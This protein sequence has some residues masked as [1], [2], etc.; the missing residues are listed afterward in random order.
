MENDS[1]TTVSKP[2]E[3]SPVNNVLRLFGP[4]VLAIV[5]AAITTSILSWLVPNWLIAF[6]QS[7]HG[8]GLDFFW[9]NMTEDLEHA[10]SIGP[11]AVERYHFLVVISVYSTLV[12]ALFRTFLATRNARH[13][14]ALIN[15]TGGALIALLFFILATTANF[16]LAF[17]FA[18]S[19]H[20]G[21]L[22]RLLSA[23][24]GAISPFLF[25]ADGALIVLIGA[26]F[27]VSLILIAGIILKRFH[28][29]SS[30][31]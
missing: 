14:P 23:P 16:L 9:L 26:G 27:Q 24:L 2:K 17:Y 7:A 25:F 21:R 13:G 20:Y 18:G 5:L 19:L 10:A 12:I 11:A 1:E 31:T 3:H 30:G 28:A 29:P 6:S 4:Y 22:G 8:L 15:K